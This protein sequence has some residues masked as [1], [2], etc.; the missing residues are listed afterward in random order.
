MDSKAESMLDALSACYQRVQPNDATEPVQNR[1]K[2]AAVVFQ[3]IEFKEWLP[4]MDSNH[5]LDRILNSRNLL[6]LQSR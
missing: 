3:A 1:Y 2:N 4:G 5:E 6:I